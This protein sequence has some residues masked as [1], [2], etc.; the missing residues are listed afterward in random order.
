LAKPAI[1]HFSKVP[2][3][4]YKP[5]FE[6]L[7]SLLTSLLQWSERALARFSTER[8]EQNQAAEGRI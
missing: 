4:C 1:A 2:F 8:I 5:E 6:N 3:D 7:T